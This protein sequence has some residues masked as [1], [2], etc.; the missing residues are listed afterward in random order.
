MTQGLAKRIGFPT[1]WLKRLTSRRQVAELATN[2]SYVSKVVQSSMLRQRQTGCES[3]RKACPSTKEEET[4]NGQTGRLSSI[5]F[6]RTIVL[7]RSFFVSRGHLGI[8]LAGTLRSSE[9]SGLIAVGQTVLKPSFPRLDSHILNISIGCVEIS[10][11]YFASLTTG[12]PCGQTKFPR[13]LDCSVLESVDVPERVRAACCSHRIG[14]PHRFTLRSASR[15][16]IQ[17]VLTN[18]E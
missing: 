10:R 14:S 8:L 13:P 1:L 5:M 11:S 7:M 3:C 6:R 9:R 17:M 12:I 15:R 18:A 2:R 4:R 16:L